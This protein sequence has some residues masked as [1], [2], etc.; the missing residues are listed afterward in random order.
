MRGWLTLIGVGVVWGG[1]SDPRLLGLS[2]PVPPDGFDLE[3]VI[4]KCNLRYGPR[5]IDPLPTCSEFQVGSFNPVI[6]WEGGPRQSMLSLPAVADLDGDGKPELVANLLPFIPGRAKGKLVVFKGDG[7]GEHCRNDDAGLGYASSPAIADLDGDG[8]AEIVSVRAVKQ[9]MPTA[10]L[11]QT[12]YR[13]VAFDHRCREVW[14]SEGFDRTHFDYASAVVVS[15]MDRDGSPEVV[16]G[17]VILHADGTTR[18]IGQHGSGSWGQMPGIPSF[19]GG[20]G[21]PV[22][23]A[24][25]PAVVDIDLDGIEEVIVGNAMYTPDGETKWFAGN[26]A[27]LNPAI[28][29]VDGVVAVANLDDDPEGEFVV[30]TYATLRA[31]DTDGTLLWGP[32]DLNPGH[33]QQNPGPGAGAGGGTDEDEGGNIGSPAAIGDIDGDGFPDI[34]VAAGNTLWAISHEGRIKWSIPVHDW[35]GATGASIFD[36]EGDGAEEVIY[37]D[38]R[39]IHILDG[40]T[41]LHKMRSDHH[42]SVTMMDYPVVADINGDGEAELVVAHNTMSFAFSVY[43]PGGDGHWAPARKLW[44]QHAY[45]RQNINDDLSVPTSNAPGFTTHNTWHSATDRALTAGVDQFFDLQVAA[46]EVCEV[47]CSLGRAWVAVQPVNRSPTPISAGVAVSLYAQIQGENQLVETQFTEEAIPS[48]QHGPLML[49]AVSREAAR[50]TSG[51]IVRINEDELFDECIYED[52][53]D[54]IVGRFCR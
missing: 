19:L 45:H 10:R 22:S 5:N 11:G 34:V 2:A 36:F 15:D 40:M 31:H 23:E 13:V 3:E 7:S 25:I 30:T 43:G 29:R 37:I 20:D 39:E 17:R 42:A 28:P 12:E 1:C 52:N 9:Q 48:G 26:T 6:K 24:S 53:F 46:H 49:F 44:N 38:E 16:A 8:K 54:T 47:E 35:S 14:E 33:G 50:R 21:V 51:F 41:G 18:G 27:L 32:I 4:G